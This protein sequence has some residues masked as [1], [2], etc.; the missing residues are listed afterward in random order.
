MIDSL[1]QRMLDFIRQNQPVTEQQLK[2]GL[3][4]S[5]NACRE[6]RG[7][8]RN[9]G[10]IYVSCGF[11]AFNS[12]ADYEHWLEHGGGHEKISLTAKKGI[13]NAADSSSKKRVIEFLSAQTAPVGAGEIANG[14]NL[15]RKS[16]YRILATL[17]DDGTIFH[18]YRA[19]GRQYQIASSDSQWTSKSERTSE[20]KIKAFVKYNPNKNGV[21]EDYMASPARQR[22]MAVYGRVG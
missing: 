22:L 9:A 15:P 6:N 4:I 19:K 13:Q 11:G 12:L 14:C 20:R 18:D 17:V 2:D 8:L 21:V 5:R 16:A 7:Q 10:L 1:K 3:G